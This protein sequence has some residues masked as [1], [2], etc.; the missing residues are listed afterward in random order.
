MPLLDA[1]T[2]DNYLLEGPKNFNLKSATTTSNGGGI[3]LNNLDFKPIVA[4][5]LVEFGF[6]YGL[7]VVNL[8]VAITKN[9]TIYIRS[10]D[11]SST[12]FI[13][14]ISNVV[15]D[16]NTFSCSITYNTNNTSSPTKMNWTIYGM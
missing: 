10:S 3:K 9:E 14:I 4:I 15:L 11:S 1:Y 8:P 5:A 7:N 6:S 16:D 12:S 13:M 2:L